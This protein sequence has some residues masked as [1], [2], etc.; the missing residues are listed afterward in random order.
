[1]GVKKNFENAIQFT[2]GRTATLHFSMG[3]EKNG[4]W[5]RLYSAL[6]LLCSLFLLSFGSFRHDIDL[7]TIIVFNLY[8]KFTKA[9]AS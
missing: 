6:F 8:L 7:E 4:R 5:V 3:K 9:V 1:M 2:I